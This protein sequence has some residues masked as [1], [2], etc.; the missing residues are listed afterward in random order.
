[1]SR[2]CTSIEQSKKLMEFGLSTDYA[3]LRY[4]NIRELTGLDMYVIETRDIV[5]DVL[6]DEIPAWS[7]GVLFDMACDCGVVSPYNIKVGEKTSEEVEGILVTFIVD[8]L[9]GV[10]E[11]KYAVKRWQKKYKKSDIRN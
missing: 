6:S 1:M 5:E 11:D 10:R 7:M 4:V 8:M 3:D 9:L 2:F